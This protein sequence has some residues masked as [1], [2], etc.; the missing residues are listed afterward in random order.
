M[1][2]MMYVSAYP[3]FLTINYSSMPKK[4]KQSALPLPQSPHA[5]AQRKAFTTDEFGGN[6]DRDNDHSRDH[7]TLSK[8]ELSTNRRPRSGSDR[9]DSEERKVHFGSNAAADG[10]SHTQP[11]PP[12]LALPSRDD[13]ADHSR[14]DSTLSLAPSTNGTVA[15]KR[16]ASTESGYTAPPRQLLQ[17]AHTQLLF[18]DS[19][20]ETVRQR[21]SV[22]RRANSG[23]L[24]DRNHHSAVEEHN[25]AFNLF[26]RTA[27]MIGTAARNILPQRSIPRTAAESAHEG[28]VR[29]QFKHL[30]LRDIFWIFSAF[31]TITAVEAEYGR[32]SFI[33]S[34]TFEGQNRIYADVFRTMFELISAYG[35]VGLSLGTD[36]LPTG[37]SFSHSLTGFS[38]LCIVLIMLLGRHRNMPSTCLA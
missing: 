29:G 36:D 34:A 35:T 33:S 37:V 10:V 8:G 17:R 24:D 9:S 27:T 32:V 3:I 26:I 4:F 12:T 31:L 23:K 38:K 1:Q 15:L 19:S 18:R 16:A 21:T 22:M 13:K 11:Y 2:A 6:A 7:S 25:P 20:A 5:K 28:F 30:L 14:L